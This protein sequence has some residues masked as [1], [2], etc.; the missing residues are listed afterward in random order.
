MWHAP[1]LVTAQHLH[2]GQSLAALASIDQHLG[3]HRRVEE[4]EVH[5]LP[6]QRVD[7]VR[8]IANQCQAFTHIALGVAL[9]QR[10]A[11]PWVGLQHVAQAALEGTPEGLQEGRFIHRHQLLGMLRSGR[12]YD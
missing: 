10:H 7:G 11:Y 1:A 12:P 5:T 8:G 9:T 6:G 2:I 4:A 3:Q